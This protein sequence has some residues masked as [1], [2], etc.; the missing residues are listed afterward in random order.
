MKKIR[1][2]NQSGVTLIEL[3]ASLALFGVI[4]AIAFTFLIQANLFNEQT[5]D[6]ISLTQ[7]ANLIISDLRNVHQNEHDDDSYELCL[8]SNQ[9][10]LL[11]NNQTRTITHVPFRSFVVF[12]EQL[13]S[14]KGNKQC[15]E[16]NRLQ[17]LPL[18]FTIVNSDE[19][20][21]EL[22][23]VIPTRSN[24][25]VHKTDNGSPALDE[26]VLPP[27][28]SE[29]GNQIEFTTDSAPKENNP[30]RSCRFPFSGWSSQTTLDHSTGKVCIN[31][32]I[33]QGSA[34]FIN[35][36][37][38]NTDTSL[39]LE[40][41][42]F[43]NGNLRL[44][45]NSSLFAKRNIYSGKHIH[46]FSN[47]EIQSLAQLSVVG[48]VT[49]HNE[50]KILIGT[51]SSISGSLN[52]FSN[53]I[54]KTKTLMIGGDFF[55]Q[56]NSF[57]N[58]DESMIVKGNGKFHDSSKTQIGGD[59]TIDGGLHFQGTSQ[60]LVGG[61]MKVRG[62]VTPNWKPDSKICVNGT[63]DFEDK[64]HSSITV[65]HANSCAGQPS[66]SIYVLNN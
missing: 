50:S 49:M 6:S 8:E 47:S 34:L 7:E 13:V 59:L 1:N 58:V 64:V 38:L 27:E 35:D 4:G 62:N 45:R 37:T 42:F 2:L 56:N 24:T 31:P 36:L 10:S 51:R 30:I 44:D 32:G 43:T 18:S 19:A 33:D 20:E 55:P 12:S 60:V 46:T 3:L 23:T 29:F 5:S 39:S 16:I 21:Y 25:F 63:I 40:E 14:I 41:D 53:T 11:Q 66:G 28:V 57:L 54:F 26:E 48:D 52:Q 15:Q 17:P 9:L 22:Q 61:D 65:K